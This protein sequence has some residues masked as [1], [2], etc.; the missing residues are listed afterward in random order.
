MLEKADFSCRVEAALQRV[1]IG[2]GGRLA[3]EI[4]LGEQP[5]VESGRRNLGEIRDELDRFLSIRGVG[6]P[7]QAT[8]VILEKIDQRRTFCLEDVGFGR[9]DRQFGNAECIL[10]RE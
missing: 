2:F 1:E 10:L 5:A 8:Q 6:V 7:S 3:V 9:P 4:L